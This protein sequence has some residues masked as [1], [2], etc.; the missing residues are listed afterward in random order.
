MKLQ[1]LIIGLAFFCSSLL[2]QNNKD[3]KR[4]L[5]K[6]FSFSDFQ[7]NMDEFVL[8]FKTLIYCEF[9]SIDYQIFM[10]PQGV[11]PMVFQSVIELGMKPEKKD[12]KFTFKD[13][14]EQLMEF[15]KLEV[16]SQIRMVVEAKNE[17][18]K[19]SASIK[20]WNT[21]KELLIKMGFDESHLNDIHTIVIENDSKPY[22]EIFKIFTDSIIAQKERQK[23]EKEIYDSKLKEENPGLEEWIKGLYVY[24]DYDLGLKKSK[25]L[26]KPLLIYFNCYGCV[27]ARRIEDKILLEPDIQNYI[28]NKLILVN[29]FVDEKSKLNENEIYFSEVLKID[30]KYTGQINLE[31]EMKKFNSDIQPLFVLLDLNGNEISRI[32]Y[33]NKLE[34]FKLFLKTIEK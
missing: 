12:K 28:N 33:T 4:I 13:L 6:E 17:I 32:G 25:E 11:M 24:K 30:V 18:I 31:L 34:D 1:L 23:I 21:D 19:R 9:D 10:G 16:Y 29:L 5:K 26:N 15:K 2:G 3:C 7:E 27:N 22:S 14:K 8:D 20:N